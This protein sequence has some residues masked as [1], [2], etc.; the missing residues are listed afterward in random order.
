[1]A[2]ASS[3]SSRMTSHNFK[4]ILDN[5]LNDYTKQMGVDLAKYDFAKQLEGCRSSED[6]L[7]L[8]SDKAGQFKE[9][10]EGN[11]KLINWMKPIVQVV[12]VLSAFLGEAIS[13][14]SCI[15]IIPL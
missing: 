12:H 5:A 15:S 11:R 9:Y 2:S 10:R 4:T 3:S 13:I 1:M 14:V 7:R 6:V 8:F